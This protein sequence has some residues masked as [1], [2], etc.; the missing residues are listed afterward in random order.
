MDVSQDEAKVLFLKSKI[1]LEQC[2]RTSEIFQLSM[3]HIE[4]DK[5]PR[6]EARVITSSSFVA[7][8]NRHRIQT[9]VAEMHFLRVAA[10]YELLYKK[11][12]N[13]R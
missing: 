3:I 8:Q 6:H 11:H 7:Q 12:K 2:K 10:G 13:I 1:L 5:E 4:Q 9:E